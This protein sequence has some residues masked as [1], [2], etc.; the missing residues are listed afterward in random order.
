MKL[1]ISKLFNASGKEELVDALTDAYLDETF[2]KYLEDI[3]VI[4]VKDPMDYQDAIIERLNDFDQ[5]E[6]YIIRSK[7]KAKYYAEN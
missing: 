2:T 6:L 3:G 5:K 4:I 7:I 1:N